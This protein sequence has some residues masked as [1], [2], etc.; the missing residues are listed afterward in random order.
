[1]PYWETIQ[2]LAKT[3]RNAPKGKPE[4]VNHHKPPSYHIKEAFEIGQGRDSYSKP[5]DAARILAKNDLTLAAEQCPELKALLSTVL[6]LCE[7][8]ILP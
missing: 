7:G 3:N 8:E 1:M 4:A 5:R 6:A 2:R